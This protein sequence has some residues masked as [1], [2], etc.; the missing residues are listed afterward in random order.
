MKGADIFLGLSGP[1]VVKPAMIRSMAENPLVFALS[2]PVPEILPEEVKATRS[3]AIIATGRSD[4]PNQVNNVLCFP[5]SVVFF[6]LEVV[7]V[8]V[9]LALFMFSRHTV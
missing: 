3:D 1:G 4:Y 9:C 5:L 6:F 8:V 7:F 2:N